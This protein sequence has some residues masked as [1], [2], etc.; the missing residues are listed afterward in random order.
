MRGL[1]ATAIG[2]VALAVAC[3]PTIAVR[4]PD[5]ARGTRDARGFDTMAALASSCRD[6]VTATAEVGVSGR[7]AGHRVRGTLQ[8]GLSRPDGVRIEAVAPFGAPIFVLASTGDDTTV[9]VLPRE[10]AYVKGTSVAQVLDA[11]IQV[12]LTPD[13]LAS[14]LLAC[15]RPPADAS[16]SRAFPGGEVAAV[17]ASGVTVFARPAPEARVTG[18][19]FGPSPTRA[20]PVALAFPPGGTAVSRTIDV[21]VGT[22]SAPSAQLRLKVTGIE[23]GVALGADAFAVAIPAGARAIGLDELRRLSPFAAA[24]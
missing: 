8:I 4:L 15:P 17:D 1:R 19:W 9:L 14:A 2:L 11:L 20:L 13:D 22:P 16:S 18:M 6:Q 7:A 5:P 12:P 3:G 10:Q 21:A 23:R 24:P